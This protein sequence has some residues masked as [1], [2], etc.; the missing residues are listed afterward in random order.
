MFDDYDDKFGEYGKDNKDRTNNKTNTNNYTNIDYLLKHY[1]IASENMELM[2]DDINYMW[3]DIMNMVENNH[4]GFLDKLRFND[5]NL[6]YNYMVENSPVAK[7]VITNFHNISDK[8]LTFMKA[9][10]NIDLHNYRYNHNSCSNVMVNIC[11]DVM[12]MAYETYGN[13]HDRIS[14]IND[15]IDGT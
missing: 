10:P 7:Q 6:F 5:Y 2:S 12:D 14:E 1:D 15:I 11:N 8:L 3:T 9:N 13:D 4:N